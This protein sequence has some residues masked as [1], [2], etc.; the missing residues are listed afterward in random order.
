MFNRTDH[1][2]KTT[3][4]LSWAWITSGE[5]AMVAR[6]LGTMLMAGLEI[7]EALDIVCDQLKGGGRRV[8]RAV[9]QETLAGNPLAQSMARYPHVFPASLV[10]AVRAGEQA[11]VIAENLVHAA[12]GL[13]RERELKAAIRGALY[14]P[15]IIISM[16][17]VLGAVLSFFVLPRIV[18]ILKGLHV[19]LPLTTRALIAFTDFISRH[20]WATGGV[21][22]GSALFIW[23]ILRQRVVKPFSHQVLLVLP[24][25]GKISRESNLAHFSRT[26]STMLKSGLSVNEAM[27]IT[28]ESLPNYVYRQSAAV[29]SGRLQSGESISAVMGGYKKLFPRQVLSLIRVGEKS[30]RLEE[31]LAHI[32]KIYES[33]VDRAAKRLTIIIEPLLLIAIGLAVGLLALSIITPIYKITGNLYH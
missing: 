28:G 25:L 20:G 32:G 14:Y 31:E 17:V 26:L 9:Q 4:R 8:L 27:S 21:M 6:Q 18:P 15:L 23:W 11:G 7:N 10:A 13:E 33:E 12:G 3:Q 1:T 30:G 19:E 2:K 5:R 16:S 24:I 29:I 22:L